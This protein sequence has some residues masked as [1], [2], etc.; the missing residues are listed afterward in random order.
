[1][2]VTSCSLTPQEREV[3]E[4]ILDTDRITF[5]QAWDDGWVVCPTGHIRFVKND[6]P[7]NCRYV[8]E[9]LMLNQRELEEADIRATMVY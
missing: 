7:Y 2:K 1:M 6:P 9:W 8:A 4:K 3:E 5:N